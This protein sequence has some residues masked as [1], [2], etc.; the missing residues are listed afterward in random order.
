VNA[1]PSRRAA[2]VAGLTALMAAGAAAAAPGVAAPGDM[3]LGNPRA[4]V[5]VVEYASP[6]C[7]HC[8]HFNEAVFAPFK[9][10]YLDTGRAHYTLKEFLTPPHQAAAAAFL[11]ARCGAAAPQRYFSVLDGIFRSQPRWRA[12]AIKPVLLEVGR[13]NGLTNAQMEACLADP[14][15]VQALDA[16]ARRAVTEDGV[17]GTPTVFVNGRKVEVQTLADLEA[18]IGSAGKK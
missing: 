4:K 11:I 6:T 2:L 14:A 10:K 16:R 15:A 7:S 3:S 18:A 5:K 13:A 8:A 17:E 12:G 1:A 9:A